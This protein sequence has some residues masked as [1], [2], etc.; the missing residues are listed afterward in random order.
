MDW[1][2]KL[3][4]LWLSVDA[5]ILATAWYAIRA[6]KPAV[7]GLWTRYVVVEVDPEP[8]IPEMLRLARR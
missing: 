3:F 6:I 7:P 8:T 2:I 4:V 5:F 1:F